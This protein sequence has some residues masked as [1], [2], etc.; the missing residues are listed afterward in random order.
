MCPGR[1]DRNA[2]L[3]RDEWLGGLPLSYAALN[4]RKEV[5]TADLP[6][7]QYDFQSIDGRRCG[8]QATQVSALALVESDNLQGVGID[9]AHGMTRG[10]SASKRHPLDIADVTELAHQVGEHASQ[11]QRQTIGRDAGV[12]AR[13]PASRGNGD[14]VALAKGVRHL[15][16]ETACRPPRILN[17]LRG[18]QAENYTALGLEMRQLVA[19]LG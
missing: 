17:R 18:R 10:I 3:T 1:C 5:V 19:R 11:S 12:Q 15:A 13:S 4:A 14:T 9:Q 7:L 2:S 8:D 6:A 16:E